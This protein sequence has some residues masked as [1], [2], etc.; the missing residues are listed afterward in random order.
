MIYDITQ[1]LPECRVF[2]G[3]DRPELTRVK[4]ME[5]G[6]EYNLTNLSLCAHN[7]THVDAPRHCLREGKGVDRLPPETFLGPAYVAA[8]AGDVTA[9]DARRILER[10][11]QARPG[12]EK[13]ILI[14]G[15]ATVTLAAAAGSVPKAMP[16]PWT[17]GQETFTSSQPTCSSRSSSP[18]V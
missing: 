7:G 3:D 16:P 10:A 18:A 12:A 8:H 2:P 11:K 6:D 13:R 1:P 15:R 17:L 14:K 5:R 4:S 9:Q